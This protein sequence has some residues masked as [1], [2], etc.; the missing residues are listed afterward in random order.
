MKNIR[1]ASSTKRPEPKKPA[2]KK[3]G[4]KP[5]ERQLDSRSFSSGRQA[6]FTAPTLSR[7]DGEKIGEVLQ[8][9]LFA[10][11][12]LSLTLKHIHWNV[13]GPN[14]IGV[15]QML[16]PQYAGVSELIDDL[17][18]RIATLGTSPAGLPGRL[19]ADRTWDDYSL[20]RA[21]AITHL[22]ALDLVYQGV[23]SGHRQ[24]MDRVEDIDRVSEDLLIGQTATLERF[25][26]FVRSHLAD[27]AGGMANAGARS[28]LGAAEAVA[29]KS[30]RQTAQGNKSAV[31][32]AQRSV[33]S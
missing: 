26:W 22:G 15:H 18:E 2:A 19:V 32:A 16:D 1:A 30:S 23:I 8:E 12:D 25:H 33:A 28:E 14:F 24:A 3:R 10:L 31:R 20:D 27:F 7:T 17:A 13:V 4:A 5:S 11:I 29:A 21:D 9:R 6:S